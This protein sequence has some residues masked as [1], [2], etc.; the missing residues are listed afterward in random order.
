M[1]AGDASS[2]SLIGAGRTASRMAHYMAGGLVRWCWL[3][4]GSLSFLPCGP[5]QGMLQYSDNM[6]TDFL[7]SGS[8]KREEG[9][10]FNAFII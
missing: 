3:L 6:A 5:L 8:S 2:G 10:K 4:E 1:S 7:Q 9:G